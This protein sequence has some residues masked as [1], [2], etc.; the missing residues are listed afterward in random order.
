MSDNAWG[1]IAVI[2]CMWAVAFM[3]WAYLK[4]GK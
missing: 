3:V 4:Y 2:G 1:S